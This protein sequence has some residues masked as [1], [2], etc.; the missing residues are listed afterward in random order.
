MLMM[1][2]V[3]MVGMRDAV[4]M[5]VEVRVAPRVNQ[6][7]RPQRDEYPA[8]QERRQYPAERL[9]PFVCSRSGSFAQGSRRDRLAPGRAGGR[10]AYSSGSFSNQPAAKRAQGLARRFSSA[11]TAR[12]CSRVASAVR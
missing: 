3:V 12:R 2:G 7:V 1:I 10:P 11:A 5:A 8:E 4:G 9:H 6:G